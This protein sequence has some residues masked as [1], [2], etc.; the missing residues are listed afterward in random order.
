MLLACVA[1]AL[2]GG[3]SAVA[4]PL[5]DGR[6]YELVSPADTGIN[7]A[8]PLPLGNGT[9]RATADG[10][11]L[12]YPNAVPL[13]GSNQGVLNTYV[14]ERPGA[15]GWKTLSVS[16]PAPLPSVDGSSG[17]VPP[18]ASGPYVLDYSS[19]LSA[20]V[21]LS[22]FGLGGAPERPGF[23]WEKKD[24]Y[25]SRNG[26]LDWITK[27][28]SMPPAEAS[29]A[30]L[31]AV[32]RSGPGVHV[33]FKNREP[34][35]PAFPSVTS[36][37]YRWS[38]G[39][40]H[41]TLVSL[42]EA[43]NPVVN[44]QIGTAIYG[45]TYLVTT[46]NAISADGS[47]VVFSS[48]PP[49]E[50]LRLF[51]RVGSETVKVAETPNLNNIGLSFQGASADGTR[52]YFVLR[53]QIAGTGAPADGGLY[54]ARVPSA[55]PDDVEYEFIADFGENS[56]KIDTLGTV[57]IS[58]NGRHVYYV[59]RSEGSEPRLIHRDTASGED[60]LVAELIEEDS[61][62][63][64]EANL[65]RP[66]RITP[67]GERLLFS[68]A[69]PG[70]GSEPYDN[71]G[72]RQLFLYDAGSEAPPTCVSCRSSAD[73][74][75]S[76]A[77]LSFF[78]TEEKP[79]INLKTDTRN[80][81]DDGSR[82]FFMSADALVPQ[83]QNGKYDVYEWTG[84]AV[85]L[86]S[87]G[88]G[89]TNSYFLDASAN[90]DD[91]FFTSFESQSAAQT[92]GTQA[93]YNARVGAPPPSDAAPPAA[94][95]GESCRQESSGPPAFVDPASMAP[96]DRPGTALAV[97]KRLKAKGAFA[98]LTVRVPAAGKTRLAGKW[99]RTSAR[100]VAGPGT[101]TMPVRLTDAGKRLLSKRGVLRVKVRLTFDPGSG[102]PISRPVLVI[103]SRKGN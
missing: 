98:R 82:V 71:G 42:D 14:A 45:V 8:M 59:E 100:S 26:N 12:M 91:V 78:G 84:G 101:A 44:P 62:L 49:D 35:D 18:F 10:R 30:E 6:N 83:D 63:W 95:E 4:N 40:D 28:L 56:N 69:A 37:L 99:V 52:I 77:V 31:A 39:D 32:N 54:L 20:V 1:L 55:D 11:R 65:S 9:I 87:S 73:A 17:P 57:A 102:P 16:P 103:F 80:L 60:R 93:I 7:V 25:L 70:I 47:R 79:G 33:A 72:N 61:S 75:T 88:R 43:G 3:A 27:P 15:T 85:H 53:D 86:I 29:N 97:R 81:S 22:A 64:H 51:V 58:S 48:F 5:P 74:S 21:V 34:E 36:G 38:E 2:A 89:V 46:T 19:D 96:G 92:D 13:P 24:L 41:P 50:S 90:G 68:S 94:C 23:F 66:A 76:P 67:D